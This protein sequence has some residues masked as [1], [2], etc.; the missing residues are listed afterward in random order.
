[1]RVAQ[2]TLDGDRVTRLCL[3]RLNAEQAGPR[4][5]SQCRN[6]AV[7][8]TGGGG[9]PT[10]I[11]HERA[12]ELAAARLEP[13]IDPADTEWLNRHL[14]A[15]E[16]CRSFLAEDG[17]EAE[18][19][20]APALDTPKQRQRPFGSMPGGRRRFGGRDRRPLVIATILVLALAVVGGNLAWG[21]AHPVS[22]EL[23]DASAAPGSPK[24]GSAT[25]SVE[26][27]PSDAAPSGDA[28]FPVLTAT[29]ATGPVVA[30]NAGFRLASAD[31]TPAS[32][33]AAR[34]TVDPSF[35]FSVQADAAD[36]VATIH[37]T[38]PLLAGVVYRFELRG[39][40]GELLDTWAFQARQ[41]L[42]IV[43]TLPE[44]EAT[45]VPVDTGIEM[46]FD[47]DGVSD[48]ASH[49]TI[50][51][52]TK[53]RFEQHGRVLVFVPD[54]LRAA[55]LY[56]VTV[57]RGVTLA[58]TGESTATDVHFQFETAASSSQTASRTFQFS[59]QLVE[60]AT[61][62]RPIIGVWS[63]SEDEKPPKT[64][65]ITVYRLGGLE[66]AID[67]FQTIRSRP[68]WARWSS[69]GLVP[70]TKL[71]HV[72]S[73][74]ARLH[75]ELG[76]DWIQLPNRLRTGWYLVEQDGGTRPSQLVL[77]VTD[78][79]GYLAVSETKTLVWAN[80]LTTGRAV[81]GASIA[82]EGTTLG[83]T[84]PRGLLMTAT[85]AAIGPLPSRMC[86]GDCNPV[87]TIRASNGRAAFLPAR[88]SPD[89]LDSYGGSS[90][91][92][93]DTNPH[94]WSILHTDRNRY[95]STD[96]VNVWGVLRDR[97]TG[98]TPPI[99]VQ[100]TAQS[101][102][103]GA[104]APPITTLSVKPGRTGAFLAALPLAGLAEGYYSVDVL[105]GTD[106]VRSSGIVV[107]PIAK[108]AYQLAIETGRHIYLAGDRIRVTVHARFFEGTP[109]P[110]I[111]LRINGYI[112]RTV[113]TDSSGNATYRTTARVGDQDEGVGLNSID[114][115]P[116]RAEEAEIGAASNDFLV[117]PSSRNI[118]ASARI[119]H[120]KVVATGRVHLVDVAR[121][122]REVASGQSIWGLDPDGAAVRGARVTI[123]FTE[124][125]PIRTRTG[126]RYDFIEKK[127]VPVYD[128]RI[129]ERAAGT[130]TTTTRSDGTWAASIRASKAGHD[131]EIKASVADSDGRVARVS[132][133]ATVHP[134]SSYEA[135]RPTLRPTGSTADTS[136]T[137]GIGDRVDVTMTDPDL[138][139][140]AGDRTRYLFFVAQRGL[141]TAIV[142]SSPRFVTTFGRSS[143]PN[144]DIG[145][146]R[147]T[148]HGYVGTVQFGAQFRIT[149]RHLQV[150]LSIPAARYVPGDRAT[151]NVRTRD[152]DGHPIGATVILRAIDEKLYSIGAAAQDDPLAE[153][154]ASVESGIVGI[155]RT[156][157]TPQ[158]QTEG[159]DTGGG[160][161]DARDDFRDSLLFEEIVTDA[162]G[163]GSVSFRLSDDLTS[164][165][166]SAAAIT[167]RLQV[168]AG[169]VL[170]PVGLPFFVDASLAS[171]YLVTDKP[172]IDVRAF[173]SALR[174]GAAVTF[175]VTS[176]SLA[177][178]SGPIRG[179]AFET[180]AIPL[181][182]LRLG[183][184]TITISATTGSGTS[185]RRDKL[186]RTFDVVETR[187][188]RSRSSYVELPS[189]GALAGGDGLT[190]IVVS[191]ASAGR[192]LPL[193]S[194]LAAGVGARV[195]RGL[196]ADA[197]AALLHDRFGMPAIDPEADF[198]ASRYQGQDGGIA[199][200]PYASSDLDL[201]ALV[202]IVAP[203]RVDRGRLGAYLATIHASA[204]ETR[205]RRMFALTGLA[206]L[207]E[208][209]LPQL[210]SAAG[211]PDLTIRERLMI[212]L[213]AA[214]LGD[215]ATART[216]ASSLIAESGEQIG[217]MARLRVGSSAADITHAT[218]LMA[219]LSAAIGDHRA[220]AFWA[221]VEANPEPEQ[222]NVLPA[223]AYVARSI[224]HLP[225]VAG[226]FAYTIG[227]RRRVVDLEVGGSFRL[228][229][230]AAQ[231]RSATF[232]RIDGSIGVTTSWSEPVRSSVFSPDPDVAMSRMVFPAGPVDSSDLIRV[233][234]HVS[235]GPQAEAGCH[236]VTE[237]VPSG[238]AP[239]GS[240][241][242]WIDPE[243]P[244]AN[245]H[246]G[247]VMP[248]DQSGSRV[249]FCAEPT[250][251]QRDFVLRYYARVVTP[252]TYAW[253]SAVAESRS[254]EGQ[255]TL[256]APTTI[257]VR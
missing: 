211:D 224:E 252:G 81:V 141:R 152:A 185:M 155:Y 31:A 234:L 19:A 92:Y 68:E 72:L 28:S 56:K 117:F 74:D 127:V 111:P 94:Y 15:C 95:R 173:G 213:G 188:T 132:S 115:V 142:Q 11:D 187:L 136:P 208:S 105:V 18:E 129:V 257:V 121:M 1:M 116:A 9:S 109:V 118:D 44:N 26:P 244:E 113:M 90:F 240:L 40:S 73:T 147:F 24:T 12:R 66:A 101:Y 106:V 130:I 148:G 196:S 17:A 87:V 220:P 183:R 154:Y 249:L 53:G 54:S 8:P 50:E 10:M 175:A 194:D 203:D 14:D 204:D 255:A 2:P 55:T 112:D 218:A 176:T 157:R 144:I 243:D 237:L 202:A 96:T 98:K 110:G 131:Y 133:T 191:D 135:P 126:S 248:Y 231:L 57:R 65:K 238:L 23:A 168:G 217:E 209:V 128:T 143:I 145:A 223:V 43:G 67:A 42:R 83:R 88:S 200:F 75:D 222:L 77:Q 33:L 171:T 215:S 102:D 4:S 205:E 232:E 151:V 35:A 153:L 104:A 150:D 120:R 229:V 29:G 48:A 47:Q 84:D 76:T 169:S 216:I 225:V 107:G 179:T 198:Q 61:A 181:P 20:A 6:A 236:Q 177:F 166:V 149:D 46:T 137:F 138:K 193:L 13:G 233:E 239:V 219:V 230:T 161:G 160:G 247:V 253:E 165:R 108:P 86:D 251:T 134:W 170:V 186:T 221:Y 242:T 182:R 235:F 206:A 228:T 254:V 78:I 99:T 119:A 256:T 226:R 156:H 227:G 63:F 159:G 79:A 140:S 100:L 210:R 192:Y 3:S 190:T 245:Q 174:P 246:P 5:G 32:R 34:L 60:S 114:A 80:D 178:E 199:L 25:P 201:S 45:D 172:A 7:R 167:S 250:T 91:Y 212:G 122:E 162:N 207:G 82:T 184:Q 163:L 16:A 97:D 189:A 59:D 58:G 124:L 70:T 158:G 37:P 164:W 27:M 93:G 180:V 21:P 139:Q 241:A 38:K 41:P 89:K 52:A 214:A 64:L 125:L 103:S 30:L 197:A 49:V 51:P 195:D 22:G 71:S 123:R 85:P 62:E 69:D 36:R 146:V 39:N